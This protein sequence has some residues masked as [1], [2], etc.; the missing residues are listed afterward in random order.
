MNSP[1][2]LECAAASGVAIVAMSNMLANNG[3]GQ[4]IP[5][6]QTVNLHGTIVLH[7]AMYLLGALLPDIDNEKSWVGRIVHVPFRHRTWTHALYIPIVLIML[8]QQ[9]TILLPLALGYINHLLCDSI[10]NAG[11]CWFYPFPGYIRYDNGAFVKRGHKLKLYRTG[12]D[13]E[14]AVTIGIIAI[15]ILVTVAMVYLDKMHTL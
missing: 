1:H 4:I 15:S 7:F 5:T 3:F 11:I 9:F 12:S 2:H 6:S 14:R 8:S 10:S 13:E